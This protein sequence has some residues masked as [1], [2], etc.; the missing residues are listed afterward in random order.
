ML[1]SCP[2][3]TDYTT[4][5]SVGA[6]CQLRTNWEKFP[7]V[8]KKSHLIC[9]P[10][11][12]SAASSATQALTETAQWES[13]PGR[14][15]TWPQQPKLLL[16]PVP[17]RGNLENPLTQLETS[18]LQWPVDSPQLIPASLKGFTVW[19]LLISTLPKSSTNNIHAILF[20]LFLISHKKC[21]CGGGVIQ[22]RKDDHRMEK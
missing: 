4:S 2:D 11:L 13:T 14:S 3:S 10:K 19:H 22:L 15:G 20:T 1:A 16:V 17:T 6:R 9:K 21:V 18:C 5:I 8:G 12:L 7:T